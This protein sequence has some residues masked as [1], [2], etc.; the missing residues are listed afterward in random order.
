MN[1]SIQ[2]QQR[3]RMSTERDQRGKLMPHSFSK[4]ASV[5][6]MATRMKPNSIDWRLDQSKQDKSLQ[7]PCC[8]VIAVP[9]YPDIVFAG[10]D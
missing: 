4:K 2:I 9:E 7:V 6:M 8:C 10:I 3:V 5:D 1:L